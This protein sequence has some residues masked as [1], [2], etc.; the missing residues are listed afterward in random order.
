MIPK[1][2]LFVGN[3]YEILISKKSSIDISVIK[4]TF[5]YHRSIPE[6]SEISINIILAKKLFNNGNYDFDVIK[7]ESENENDPVLDI[8]LDPGTYVIYVLCNKESYLFDRERTLRLYI[9]CNNYY[10]L[11]D[12]GVD[13]NYSFLKTII[14]HKCKDIAPEN[15]LI[16]ITKNKISQK[17]TIGMFYLKNL[18]G[19]EKTFKII[20]DPENYSLLNNFS[21][22]IPSKDELSHITNVNY[23]NNTKTKISRDNKKISSRISIQMNSPSKSFKRPTNYTIMN[24][25]SFNSNYNINNNNQ[26]NFTSSLNLPYSKEFLIKLNSDEEFIILGTRNLYYEEYWFNISFEEYTNNNSNNNSSL[27]Y[28]SEQVDNSLFENLIHSTLDEEFLIRPNLESYDY[29]FK[30]HDINVNDQIA[31]TIDDSNMSS[32]YFS[33]KYPQ[34]MN[35]INKLP[36]LILSESDADVKVKF[37]DVFDS[38]Y[39]V[40][41]GE[42]KASKTSTVPVKHGRGLTIFGDGSKHVGYY[43]NDDFNGKGQFIYKDGSKISIN[44]TNGKMHGEGIQVKS[45]VEKKCLYEEGCL[46]KII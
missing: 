7:L 8:E 22:L 19:N 10:L 39:G 4:K 27:K 25:V 40:Y 30:R 36:P 23:F 9:V 20:C 34:F 46:V 28:L 29:F 41:F 14:K 5:R 13:K 45:G 17:S 42:W 43:E 15:N 38:G 24:K 1:E 44:F 6:K 18:F 33:V 2:R 11:N 35:I 3:V 26:D 32:E 21:S 16:T 37:M 31:V 12:V